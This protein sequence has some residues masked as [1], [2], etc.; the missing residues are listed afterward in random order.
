MEGFAA[1]LREEGLCHIKCLLT[2]SELDAC[3]EA[4]SER[5]GGVLRAL[6]LKQ[7]LQIKDGDDPLPTRFVEVVERDGGRLD[8]RHGLDE[9]PFSTLLAAAA[10][11]VPQPA[12]SAVYNRVAE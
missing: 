5:L 9:E 1:A 2:M 12:L 3:R 8:V 11:Q 4:A 7:V 10:S 6:L